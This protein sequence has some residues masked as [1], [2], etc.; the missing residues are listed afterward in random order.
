MRERVSE[1]V[2][3]WGMQIECVREEGRLRLILCIF[4]ISLSHS[5]NSPVQIVFC[6]GLNPTISKSSPVFK[7]PCSIL[8]VHTVPLPEIEKVS[9]TGMRKGFSVSLLGVGIEISTYIGQKEINQKNNKER[10][11]LVNK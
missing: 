1:G 7:H 2:R 4:S 11:Q 3:V 9:S 8:P 5:L 10:S 6:S